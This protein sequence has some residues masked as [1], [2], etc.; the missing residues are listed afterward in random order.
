MLNVVFTT[1]FKKELKKAQRRGCDM[2]KINRVI[3]LLADGK[4]L[5]QKYRDHQLTNYS[6]YEN[7][8]E[9]HIEPDWLLVYHVEGDSLSLILLRT[10]TH[11][12]LF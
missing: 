2:A 11:S 7:V 4:K 8:R 9:C 1:K 10:G 12:D 5:P 3:G 6:D